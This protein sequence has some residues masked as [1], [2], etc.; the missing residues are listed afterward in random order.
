MNEKIEL[1]IE[2]QQRDVSYDN[3]GTR[4]RTGRLWRS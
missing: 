3:L 4:Y 2:K 1:E